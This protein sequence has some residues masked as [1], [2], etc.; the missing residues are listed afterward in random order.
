[1]RTPPA[2]AVIDFASI[3]AGVQ[4]TDA[5]L[6]KAPVAFFR[7]G[8]VTRG[9]YLTLFGGSPAA[10][11]EALEEG[12][13]RGGRAVLDHL[14]LADVHPRLF[15]AIGGARAP[16]SAGPLALVETDTV[17]S[18][19]LAAERALKGTGVE[20]VEVR[21]ADE[22]LAGKG[23]AVFRGELHDLEAALEIVRAAL[24]PGC[25][26]FTEILPRPHDAFAHALAMGTAF[27]A[28]PFVEL[29]GEAG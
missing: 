1:M 29:D 18:I 23:V 19:V 20:L 21:L 25:P 16:E 26:L 14:Y 22:G 24:R 7:S 12:L 3:A 27:S 11:E 2:F 5:L 15:E 28:S 17:A 4:A 10:V 13:S 8:T 9:R 6:K